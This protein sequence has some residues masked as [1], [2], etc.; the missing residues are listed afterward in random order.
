[1]KNIK[2]ITIFTL[3]TVL[4]FFIY[5]SNS[6]VEAQQADCAQGFGP[7]C[8]DTSGTPR[9]LS[10]YEEQCGNGCTRSVTCGGNGEFITGECSCSGIDA[11]TCPVGTQ[12]L[13]GVCQG[14]AAGTDY[15]TET[16]VPSF[17]GSDQVAFR[18]NDP[19]TANATREEANQFEAATGF[20]NPGSFG[21]GGGQQA[22]ADAD[23]LRGVCG[24]GSNGCGSRD[25]GAQCDGPGDRFSGQWYCNQQ[26][27]KWYLC[28]NGVWDES[29]AV[30]PCF[31]VVQGVTVPV[32]LAELAT[33]DQLDSFQSARSD[34]VF[35]N[36]SAESGVQGPAEAPEASEPNSVDVPLD[37]SDGPDL[38]LPPINDS[39]DSN[40]NET[41]FLNNI[42]NL[43]VPTVSA[44]P[45]P[46]VIDPTLLD[47]GL[48]DITISGY[49]TA[50]VNISQNQTTV[51]Y[52]EDL[53][54]DGIRQSNEQYIDPNLYTIDISIK[55]ATSIFDFEP[56]WNVI[57][58]NLVNEDIRKTSSFARV[59]RDS[60][61]EVTQI[62][63]YDS[64]KWIHYVSR[65]DNNGDLVEY[66]ND[67][68]LVPGEG[69]FVRVLN[70]GSAVITGNY[71]ES[72]AP[73][74][75]QNG[76]NLVGVQ[77]RTNYTARTFL[78][79]CNNQG[80]VCSNISRFIGGIYES[81]VKEGETYF[82][83]NFDI[84]YKEGYF[85]LNDGDQETI[86]P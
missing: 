79:M 49:R 34:S 18:S 59:L 33:A 40:D 44:Q 20:N 86:V 31:E 54:G 3:V 84:D 7:T 50:E 38:E 27:N 55:Q 2:I 67:Y 19:R 82:G 32:N 29:S 39:D 6:S 11:V 4:G 58:L 75:L 78:E 48:Y 9:C 10:A 25:S 80:A 57:T 45:I 47:A 5:D 36:S 46:D 16:V 68:N 52:F 63:K 56:G 62:S 12:F 85:V 8:I 83:N 17:G 24:W 22:A 37:V 51:Q 76:W 21:G 74:L 53:N 14:T 77:S 65:I 28:S 66:G 43:L 1:M 35:A 61:V 15:E 13:N 73:I 30:G 42:G 41:S 70:S 81:V 60:G 26:A 23:R 72:S 64:G 69:Y 71:F